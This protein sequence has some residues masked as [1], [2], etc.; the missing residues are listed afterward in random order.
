MET[1]KILMVGQ[2]SFAISLPKEWILQNNLKLKDTI[3]LKRNSLNELVLVPYL[4]EKEIPKIYSYNIDEI[5]NLQ[6]FLVFSYVKNIN[7]I[8]FFSKN[9]SYDKIIEIKKTL[10]YLDGYQVISEDDKSVEIQFIYKE[11]ELNIQKII[12][13]MNFLINILFETVK[14]KDIIMIE[15]IENNIDKLY[16][17]ARRI[18]MMCIN[19]IKICEQNKIYSKEDILFYSAISKKLEHIGDYIYAIRELELSET[20]DIILKKNLMILN[21]IIKKPSLVFEK[22]KEFEKIEL[23]LEEKNIYYI[24]RIRIFIK[25]IIENTLSLEFNK[26]YFQDY[27]K[28]D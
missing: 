7:H 23:N 3:F 1:R 20:E 14:K 26:L 8:K 5:K 13:R 27:N 12:L 16:H 6:Q 21:E 2:K 24:R 11:I 18:V 15:E 25:D 10:M 4:K 19:D 9:I 22:S 17:L 28:N